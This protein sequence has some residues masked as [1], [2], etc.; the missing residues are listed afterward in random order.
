MRRVLGRPLGLAALTALLVVNG[1]AA[2]GSA[3]GI[4][5]AET[6]SLVKTGLTALGMP[7]ALATAFV[8][9]LL[10]RRAYLLWTYHRGAWRTTLIIAVT[11]SILAV[12]TLAA[13]PFVIGAWIH[14]WVSLATVFVLL[15]PAV[16]ALC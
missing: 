4:D 3:V 9:L 14:L 1:L 12:P 2:I 8:G 7:V 13:A 5:G 6:E 11:G 16:R 15:R 10:L